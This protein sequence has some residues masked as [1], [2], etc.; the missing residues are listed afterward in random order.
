MSTHGPKMLKKLETRILKSVGS[1][2]GNVPLSNNSMSL[3]LPASTMAYMN[4]VN[5]TQQTQSTPIVAKTEVTAVPTKEEEKNDGK[6]TWVIDTAE[7]PKEI[8]PKEKLTA[9]RSFEYR[10]QYSGESWADAEDDPLSPP[11]MFTEGGRVPIP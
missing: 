3:P 10:T 5:G 7:T 8:V 11:P 4:Q 9:V 2:N 1:G 6:E